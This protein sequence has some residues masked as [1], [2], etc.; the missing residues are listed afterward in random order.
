MS[1]YHGTVGATGVRSAVCPEPLRRALWLAGLA[2]GIVFTVWL[3]SAPA[4]ADESVPTETALSDTTTVVERTGGLGDALTTLGER[5]TRVADEATETVRRAESETTV[6]VQEVHDAVRN[7]SLPHVEAPHSHGF[8]EFSPVAEQV[9]DPALGHGSGHGRA[10]VA[11]GAQEVT[12][13]IEVDEPTV[14][15]VSEH[16]LEQAVS[17]PARAPEAVTE[18][19]DDR[20]VIDQDGFDRASVGGNVPAMAPTTAPAPGGITSAPT[21]AGFLTTLI[22]PAPASGSFK[23]AR[24]FLGPVPTDP[25]DEPT[26]SPD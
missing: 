5:V 13:T 19:I 26:F 18:D 10:G 25:A 12:E 11:G 8:A 15:R 23:A 21:V 22:A 7:V 14:T 20:R 17:T 16:L 2:L 6:P 4:H 24:H 9:V 1:G 3:W